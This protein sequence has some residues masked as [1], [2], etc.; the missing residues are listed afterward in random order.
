MRFASEFF[1]STFLAAP[2]GM[3]ITDLEGRY[4]KVNPAMCRFVGY[5]EQELL[6]MSFS[7]IT[8]AG[9]L[10]PNLSRRRGLIAKE[11]PSFQMEK[12]YLHK[13]GREI[14][15]LMVASTV[16]DETGTPRYMIVQALDI[17]RQKRSEQFLLESRQQLRSLSV[18]Q[19]NLLEDERKRTVSKVHEE[20][21][22][23]LTALKMD[24]SL[25]RLRYGQEPALLEKLGEMRALVERT[26]HVVRRVANDL[27]PAALDL[28]LVPAIEWLAANF[29]R[30]WN[31]AC[32]V[33]SSSDEIALDDE[34]ATT[35]F[36]VVQEALTN[37]ARHAQAS[38]V[39]IRIERGE[40]LSLGVTDDG[41]GF[42]PAVVRDSPGLGLF[43]M[44]E[45]ILALGGILNIDSGRGG[46]TTVTIKL[47]LA[48]EDGI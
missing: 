38:A 4:I 32:E 5:S 10:A 17:D 33:D 47:P 14:W 21:G 48:R 15:A 46:G 30:R 25:L 1:A 20:L 6:T 16:A 31:I 45:R 3:A 9:D 39:T 28:G 12:R 8:H 35:V 41:C 44:R 43:G 36:R 24:V 7:D 19:E 29:C 42:D 13:D 27:R 23:M 26:I 40:E 2:V 18:H 22:Q 37:V 34:T 11:F